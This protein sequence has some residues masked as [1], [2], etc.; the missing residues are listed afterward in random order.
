ME[1]PASVRT[2]LNHLMA[3]PSLDLARQLETQLA[4]LGYPTGKGSNWVEI[5]N[6]D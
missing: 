6:F 4:G 3:T 1:I 2:I 5:V